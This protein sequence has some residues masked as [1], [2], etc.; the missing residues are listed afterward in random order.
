MTMCDGEARRKWQMEEE[1]RKPRLIPLGRC[2]ATQSQETPRTRTH[3]S[4]TNDKVVFRWIV[5]CFR[6]ERKRKIDKEEDNS[7]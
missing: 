1:A 3:A 4:K 2:A 7:F 6:G 5:F